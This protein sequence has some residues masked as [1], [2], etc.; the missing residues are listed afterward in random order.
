[1]NDGINIIFLD[2][3]GVLNSRTHMNNLIQQRKSVSSGNMELNRESILILKEIIN[4]TN[5]KIVLSSS[6][7]KILRNV[8][9]VRNQLKSHG[10]SLLGLTGTSQSG[11]RDD[12]IREWINNWINEKNN[13]RSFI[14]IDDDEQDIELYKDRLI[15][16]TW[17]Y[18][19]QKEHIKNSI[20]L[21]NCKTIDLLRN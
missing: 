4:K 3:D 16:T 2:I 12:E 13:I 18:G 14:I 6:W 7:R 17:M 9:N 10:I 20:E 8:V 11:K 15:H 19:L 1:M 5:A 21:L